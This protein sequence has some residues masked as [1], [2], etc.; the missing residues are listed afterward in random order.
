MKKMLFAWV[1]ALCLL[2]VGTGCY[3]TVDGRVKAGVPF[4]KDKIEGRYERPVDQVFAAAKEVMKFNGALEGENT[5][6]KT[7]W[8]K[9]DTRTVWIKVEEV[10]PK[11][12]RVIVQARK[13]GGGRDIDLASEIDKQ[14][15]LRLVKP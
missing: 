2:V 1:G 12:S 7:L 10:D 9:V 6:G 13:K 14:I 15:A 4:S 11:V 5:I 3:S 8:G